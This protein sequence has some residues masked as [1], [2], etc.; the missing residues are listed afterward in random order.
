MSS[1]PHQYTGKGRN[2]TIDDV[3]A[4]TDLLTDAFFNFGIDR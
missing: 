3:P 1:Q 4:L 2:I